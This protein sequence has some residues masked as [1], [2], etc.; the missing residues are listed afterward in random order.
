[1]KTIDKKAPILVTGA[2][3]YLA[4]WIIQ[5]LL[6]EGFTVHATVHNPN[7]K[8]SIEHLQK[9]EKTTPGQIR[10]FQADLLNEGDFEAAMKNCELV[11]HTASPFILNVKDP[12]KE[13][14]NPALKGTE[15][16][17]NTVNKTTSVKRVILTSSVVSIF[18]DNIDFVQ[19]G[20]KALDESDW[21][22]TSSTRHMPYPYSKVRAEK[23]AWE[24]N[25]AQNRWD[26]IT[27]NP[28]GIWG[29]SLTK[30]SKSATIDLLLQLADGRF[31]SGVPDL[32]LPF[33][34][35]R[36]V[37][38]AHL[39]AAFNPN[40]Q[41][42]YI[43][44]NQVISIKEMA[45]ILRPVYESEYPI[46]NKVLPKWLMW[47]M[48]PLAGTTRKFI[49]KNVGHDLQFNNEKS[50]QELDISYIDKQETIL[51]QFEQLKAD[52]LV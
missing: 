33:V 16:V 9:I 44:L 10:F 12:V 51:S 11:I 14:L 52:Q 30:T 28:G 41:G 5:Y 47:L 37:A 3:G 21:N 13:L 26:L 24:I 2:S 7:K 6:E 20:K 8:S 22:T 43:L 23:R 34:D 27:I 36:N 39:K 4:G 38:E 15:N 25:K 40:A 29:P 32:K 50:I 18:G 31:K 42:R 19:S 17:L 48:A 49:S 46:P 1:M 45:D 35:V